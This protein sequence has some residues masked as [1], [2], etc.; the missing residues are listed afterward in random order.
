MFAP[1]RLTKTADC[2]CASTVLRAVYWATQSLVLACYF[3]HYRI[4]LYFAETTRVRPLKEFVGLAAFWEVHSP[5]LLCS[6]WI[7]W[8]QMTWVDSV[9]ASLMLVHFFEGMLT[10]MS[11]GCT[12]HRP[13]KTCTTNANHTEGVVR[14]LEMHTDK[15]S[16]CQ[17]KNSGDNH[18]GRREV[19]N[20]QVLPER[21]VSQPNTGSNCEDME[22]GNHEAGI[23]NNDS[24]EPSS[25]S[26]RNPD[27]QKIIIMSCILLVLTI[28]VVSFAIYENAWNVWRWLMCFSVLCVY[29]RFIG[30]HMQLC[31]RGIQSN[32]LVS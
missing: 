30:F 5:S 24:K 10:A 9:F 3:L 28:L 2:H 15:N 18:T 26:T 17:T 25:L 23:L 7:C 21:R 12:L 1:L 14:Q 11:F 20:A 16:H 13:V 19:H 22:S 29:V 31:D 32:N 6:V 8:L 27:R 4:G